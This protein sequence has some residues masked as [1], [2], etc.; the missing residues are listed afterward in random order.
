MPA[1]TMGVTYFLFATATL[2]FV[3]GFWVKADSYRRGGKEIAFDQP[4]TRLKTLFRVALLQTRTAKKKY[5]G[6]MHLLI[7]WGFTVL[8]IGTVLVLIEYDF[9]LPVF[10]YQFLVGNFYLLFEFLLDAFGLLFLVGLGM[11]IYRR[12]WRRPEALYN[13]AQDV[14][15]LGSLALLGVQ[16]FVVESLRLAIRQPEWAPFSFAGYALSHVWTGLSEPTLMGVYRGLWWFHTATFMVWFATLPFT[17]MSHIFTSSANILFAKQ[18]I[19]QAKGELSKPFDLQQA[20]E[21]GSFDIKMGAQKL[22]DFSWRHLLN[23]DAC[24]ECGRC[25]DVCPAYAAGRPLSPMKVVLD[26]REEMHRQQQDRWR[27]W[28]GAA[29]K[30]PPE[31]LEGGPEP[32]V[33]LD[34]GAPSGNQLVESVIRSQTLWS[35]VTCR[36][37]QE[38]CPVL[39][40]HVPII[41]DMRRGLV[42]ESRIDGHMTRLLTNLANTGNAYG[43]P[44]SDRD[45]W[46]QGMEVP[47]IGDVDP[48]TLEVLYWVG[49]S[50]S[51]DSRNQKVSR[52]FVKV[53]KAARVGFAI[54]GNEERCNG[55]P[56]R[57]L[58]E[59]SRFQEMVLQNAEVFKK[60]Q[61]KRVVAQCP[62]CFN[63]LK[64]E[65]R[66]FGV[67]LEVEHHTVFV[68]RLIDTGRLELKR[69]IEGA[70]T[71]HD[72]CYLGRYNDVYAPPRKALIQLQTQPLVE[73][74]RS[75]NHSFCC[76]AGGSNMWFEV[77]EER[78]RMS[79]IRMKEAKATGA[80]RMA[81][82]CPFC[83]TMFDDAAR[84]TGEDG[85]EVKDFVELVAE[86]LD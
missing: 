41:V 33:Q 61:I 83:M 40:E 23:F 25:Q 69:K 51:Y 22:E 71:Y 76:G 80:K 37:C 85:F 18:G 15:I 74:P 48:A 67:E 20:L 26:L 31:E 60:Y 77:K 75:H 9:T 53:L 43:F 12:N 66:R 35:C 10:N 38:A 81:T 5:A 63:T 34:A 21:T 11:A 56:A 57:R 55:D 4:W 86:C 6:P 79:H 54:L 64:N 8:F 28:M 73:M 65:Y 32:G 70:T 47:R 24:T 36:A 68:Q 29:G 72:P 59:E 7:F 14:W 1:D 39:I 52:A 42:A 2:V 78:E 44:T 58:G 3:I 62:H 82:A 49:C 50:G 45:A 16:G 27:S 84:M 46:T 19:T 13:K 17:K 30:V